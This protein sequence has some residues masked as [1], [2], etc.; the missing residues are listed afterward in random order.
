LCTCRGEGEEEE[1]KGVAARGN[2]SA[3]ATRWMMFHGK[4]GVCTEG[5]S[6]SKAALN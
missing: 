3:I 6:A 1:E 5:R 2:I 4:E